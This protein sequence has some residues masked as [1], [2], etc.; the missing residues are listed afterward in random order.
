VIDHWFADGTKA[1]WFEPT[2]EF[3][4]D[5]RDRFSALHARAAGGQLD[6]WR[7]SA[8]GC[9]ALC[10]LLDQLPRNMFRD[11]PKAFATDAKALAIAEHAIANGFDEGQPTDVRTFLY[12]PFE[13]S[14]D[15]S[16]QNRCVALF[17]AIGDERLLDHAIRHQKIIERFG[18]FPH[19][20]QAL[21]RE[22]TAAEA[23]FLQ[24][25]GSSF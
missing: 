21:G 10:L 3:D 5:L 19:R 7:D 9:L 12:L 24:E 18:R 25:P 2:A 17:A 22:T 23:A 20:N 14:E 6:H 15:L 1:R 11:D 8:E 13:H 16:Q 4:Q